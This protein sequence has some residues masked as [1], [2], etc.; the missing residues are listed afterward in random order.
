MELVQACVHV[1]VPLR[2]IRTFSTTG[3]GTGGK[4]NFVYII[5]ESAGVLPPVAI[6]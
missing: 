1:H 3:A 5:W 2:G 6:A 4:N